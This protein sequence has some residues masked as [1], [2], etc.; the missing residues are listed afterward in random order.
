MSGRRSPIGP[1]RG[2]SAATTTSTGIRATT[3][4]SARPPLAPAG[5]ALLECAH[6]IRYIAMV[7]SG[8][9]PLGGDEVLDQLTKQFERDS[10][11]LRTRRGVAVEA[12]DSLDEISQPLVRVS[13]GRVTSGAGADRL[14]AN[15]GHCQRLK[16]FQRSSGTLDDGFRARR[17][18]PDLLRKR[19]SNLRQTTRFL[20]SPS[21]EST[22]VFAHLDYGPLGVNMLRNVKQAWWYSMVQTRQDIV[23]ST[24]P[25][26]ARRPC[27]PPRAT[28]E[29]FTD[30]L[31]DCRKCKNAGARTRSTASVLTAARRTSLRRGPST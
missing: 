4:V 19:S 10:L 2:T 1:D 22:A 24:P 7:Q 21:A 6:A 23:D 5:A 12:F 30:P 31:V 3:R 27:G 28:L 14:L 15:P 20:S 8:E 18:D 25:S 13:E 16:S 11:S 9:H 17:P 29:T 26:W